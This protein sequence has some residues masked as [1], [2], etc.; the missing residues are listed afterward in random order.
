MKAAAISHLKGTI[1][2]SLKQIDA[3]NSTMSDNNQNPAC[4]SKADMAE[5][6]LSLQSP[7]K[8]FDLKGSRFTHSE[9]LQFT[10]VKSMSIV[11]VWQILTL[12][13]YNFFLQEESN[14]AVSVVSSS[15]E[16]VV[17]FFNLLVFF[18]RSEVISSKENF[19]LQ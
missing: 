1:K 4:L 7:G 2:E 15:T 3:I 9:K 16:E 18:I 5:I 11:I 12:N 19:I 13:R 10:K 17:F 8:N 6:E 14:Q